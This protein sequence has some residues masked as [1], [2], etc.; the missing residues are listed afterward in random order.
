MS[1][2]NNTSIELLK[3]EVGPVTAKLMAEGVKLTALHNHLIGSKPFVMFLHFSSEGSAEKLAGTMRS[4]LATN[5]RCTIGI[6]SSRN[7]NTF[8]MDGSPNTSDGIHRFITNLGDPI[9]TY[10]H[11]TATN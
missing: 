3:N 2:T 5:S 7:F 6:S 1:L 8:R 11:A 10:Y 4:V 9:N